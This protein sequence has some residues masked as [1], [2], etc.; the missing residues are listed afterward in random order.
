MIFRCLKLLLNF[1]VFNIF[2]YILI[3]NST[4]INV[5]NEDDLIN[6]F[7]NNLEDILTINIKNTNLKITNN[8]IIDNINKNTLKKIIING[9]AK[10]DSILILDNSIN[11][12][13]FNN[14]NIKEIHINKLT[15][16]GFL[17]FVKYQEVILENVV[18]YG[19]LNFN[20]YKESNKLID[21]SNFQYYDKLNI[22]TN[23]CID[24]YGNVT[25][26]NSYFYGNPSCSDSL[27]SFKG[28]NINNLQINN[29]YFDGA[30]SNNCVSISNSS[31]S[32][33]SSSLFEKGGSFKNGG[34]LIFYF[35]FN[36]K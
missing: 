21:I 26:N 33:I 28:E 10:E 24:L 8:S 27:L 7:N 30:Y 23:N 19:R 15:I 2:H 1:V 22:K 6:G 14:E 5:N 18:L 31:K 35:Y 36:V 12:L 16:Y 32:H 9:V 4:I 17:D 11:K 34:Y 13:I 25:I 20:N 29:S 3:I